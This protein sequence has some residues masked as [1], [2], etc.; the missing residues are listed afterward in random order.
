MFFL[1]NF[2]AV[3][4]RPLRFKIFA[5]VFAV[6]SAAPRV[7]TSRNLSHDGNPVA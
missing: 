2:A 5:L 4:W 7:N 1:A 6:A 3:S